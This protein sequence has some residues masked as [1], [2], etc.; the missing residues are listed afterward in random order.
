MRRAYTLI[1]LVLV[2][3]IICILAAIVFPVFSSL[4]E[5]AR[6]SMCISNLSQ[7][8]LAVALYTED[9]DDLYP[10]GGDM[11]L[12]HTNLWEGYFD[13]LYWT[14]AQNLR[15]INEVLAPYTQATQIWKCP[16]DTGLPDGYSDNFDTY[17]AHTSLFNAFGSSYRY[18]EMLFLEPHFSSTLDTCGIGDHRIHFGPSE[19]IM[20]S[21]AFGSWHGTDGN[22][23]RNVLMAD[24][25]AISMP[26]DVY[27]NIKTD[28]YDLS[29]PCQ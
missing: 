10:A 13:G 4:R 28:G 3:A 5:S 25:H 21:D 1:E 19:V 9:F 24:G 29:V 12:T 20:F 2:I 11:Y 17:T 23:R 16:S 18:E 22:E 26:E 14:R 8:G 6:K 15:P 7:L 27:D